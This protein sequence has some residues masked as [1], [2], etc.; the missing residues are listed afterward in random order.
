M[1]KEKRKFNIETRVEGPREDEAFGLRLVRPIQIQITSNFEIFIRELS[2][3]RDETYF[4]IRG[5]VTD[6]GFLILEVSRK[7]FSS[8]SEMVATQR[9]EFKGIEK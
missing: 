1:S 6:S 2:D 5:H 3:V 4:C 7:G 9:F 8:N